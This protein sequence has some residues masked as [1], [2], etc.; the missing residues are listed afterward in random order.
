MLLHVE[1]SYQLGLDATQGGAGMRLR[2]SPLFAWIGR[3]VM[4]PLMTLTKRF[5]K[6]A[7]APAEVRP[8]AEAAHAVSREAL[9][10]RVHAYF[11]ALDALQTLRI[12]T[13]HTR[14]HAKL[15]APP[16]ITG[17]WKPSVPDLEPLR[18]R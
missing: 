7:P 11:G 9:T 2:T 18:T 15:L 16:K 1:Q 17:K 3:R 6:G 8:D 4:L 14:H 10:I 5:P 12:L 13:A